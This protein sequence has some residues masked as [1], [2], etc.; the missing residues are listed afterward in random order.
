MNRKFATSQSRSVR[1]FSVI[2]N[3][4]LYF[5]ID[6]LN[7][8]GTHSFTIP[9]SVRLK[10][11]F[12]TSY[13]IWYEKRPIFNEDELYEIFRTDLHALHDIRERGTTRYDFF[14]AVSFDRF[15]AIFVE[16]RIHFRIKLS[17]QDYS[18]YLKMPIRDS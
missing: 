10:Q 12:R 8:Y 5:S 7:L 18:R 17:L 15:L 6:H 11:N 2:S 13:L 9:N 16:F 4:P 14:C 1:R 3:F